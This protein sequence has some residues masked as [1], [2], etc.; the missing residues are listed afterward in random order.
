MQAK[1]SPRTSAYNRQNIFDLVYRNGLNDNFH[2][3]QIKQADKL[4][5]FKI[6]FI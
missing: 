1:S 2:M 4:F 3:S 6:F 5:F